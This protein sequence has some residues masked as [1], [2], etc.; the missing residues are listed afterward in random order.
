MKNPVP[1]FDLKNIGR[2]SGRF[3]KN[4]KGPIVTIG[5]R[6]SNNYLR[7]YEMTD[8]VRFELEM[9]GRLIESY[10]SLLIT[11]QLLELENLLATHFFSSLGKLLPLQSPY[12]DWL[13]LR[14]RPIRKQKIMK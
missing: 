12:L 3:D 2:N 11:H 7:I 10:H 8:V 13:I 1:L 9:K 14:L 5:N 4:Q 6:R